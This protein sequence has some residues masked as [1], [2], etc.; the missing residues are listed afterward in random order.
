MYD[1]V[2]SCLL[3]VGEI[4]CEESEGLDGTLR[5]SAASYRVIRDCISCGVNGVIL[6]LTF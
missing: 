5:L 3:F 2:S 4:W 1:G 6:S